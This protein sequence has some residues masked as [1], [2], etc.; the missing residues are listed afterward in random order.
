M[1]PVSIHY[2]PPGKDD[3]NLVDKKLYEERLASETKI[4]V[5]TR[6]ENLKV[7]PYVKIL[8]KIDQSVPEHERGDM[9]IFLS[10][11][12]EIQTLSDELVAY[13]NYTKKWIILPLHS[14]LSVA[15]QERVF[16]IAPTG[17][18]KC[19]LS[20]NLAETSV[21]IDGI[22]FIIDSGKVKEM[23]YDTD[24]RLS[25][26]Q[27]F[28]ISQ[29]SAKQRAGRAGRTGPGECYRLYSEKEFQ[30]MNDFPVPEIQ[31]TCLDPVVLQIQAYKLGDPREFDFIEKPLRST[32]E[33]SLLRLKDLE[34]LDDTENITV[35]GYALALLPIDVVLGKMLI[36][37]TVCNVKEPILIIA[38]AL[39]V[40]SP[41]LRVSESNLETA[42]VYLRTLLY[43]FKSL[44]ND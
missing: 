38:A 18:R 37:G 20:T 1:F 22:R 6:S 30:H 5:A 12:N 24:S 10:G 39:S 15:D 7:G 31:R 42:S 27:E 2:L 8:E 28:W 21:T 16:D 9:L 3:R 17:V 11:L 32:I 41:F 26:L 40:P 44:I 29:S 19:I 33:N 43:F 14:S 35:L 13:A 34:A 36:L 4:S 25:R 23:M